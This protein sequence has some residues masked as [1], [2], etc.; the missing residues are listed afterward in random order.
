MNSI[1]S[2]EQFLSDMNHIHLFNINVYFTNILLLPIIFF[3]YILYNNI[4]K[5]DI[6]KYKYKKYCLLFC[7]IF[8]I[9]LIICFIISTLHHSTMFTNYNK[10][11]K[12]GKLDSYLFA[13]LIGIFTLILYIIYIIFLIKN[14]QYNNNKLSI[15]IVSLILSILGIII[16]IYKKKIIPKNN[17]TEIQHYI[18]ICLHIMFHYL[19]YTGVILLII[20][21]IFNKEQMYRILITKD[22]NTI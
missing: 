14:K 10:L 8:I 13:P 7:K 4:L 5:W 17:A 22:Q 1:F 18:Y 20:L 2:L 12:I 11:I 3:V 15:F 21:Y 19:S 9:L 6:K 16:F